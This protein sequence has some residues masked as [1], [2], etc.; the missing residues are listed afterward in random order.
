MTFGVEGTEGVLSRL[1]K[2]SGLLKPRRCSSPQ[3]RGHRRYSRRLSGPRAYRGTSFTP[4]VPAAHRL[5]RALQ[6]DTARVYSAGTSEE[7]LGE[8]GWQKRGLVME[9]KLYPNI[10]RLELLYASPWCG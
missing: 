3:G 8:L 4:Q 2:L 10:V 6:L 7:L 1:L 9:T 5:T